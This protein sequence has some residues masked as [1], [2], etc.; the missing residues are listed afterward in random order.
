MRTWNTWAFPRRG[1][2]AAWFFGGLEA[3]AQIAPAGIGDA[4]AFQMGATTGAEG[5]DPT[6]TTD[7]IA[8]G[9]GKYVQI[10]AFTMAPLA[11]DFT[12][13]LVGKFV[14]GASDGEVWS[15]GSTTGGWGQHR[16]F[17]S[18]NNSL[19][20]QSLNQDGGS[21]S[22]GVLVLD[23]SVASDPLI[24][25]IT[26][27]TA[28]NTITLERADTW[29]SVSCT[30]T[31][32]AQKLPHRWSLGIQAQGLGFPGSATLYAAAFA[33]V[34]WTAAEKQQAATWLQQRLAAPPHNC[35]WHEPQFV[36]GFDDGLLSSYVLAFPWLES[37]GVRGYLAL[38]GNTCNLYDHGD[39]YMTWSDVRDLQDRGHEI[40]YHGFN[41]E[42]LNAGQTE[43]QIRGYIESSLAEYTQRGLRVVNGS[44]PGGSVSAASD[45]VYP[46]YFRGARAS[47]ASY[48]GLNAHA[49]DPV[50]LRSEDMDAIV[51]NPAR[52]A[53]L[54]AYV[55]AAKGSRGLFIVL[56]HAVDGTF[57][58]PI[59]ELI[60]YAQQQGLKVRTM[61]EAL[62]QWRFPYAPKGM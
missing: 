60:G 13:V 2:V 32:P 42:Y 4:P 16:L 48:N 52:L 50:H 49:L 5:S 57:E 55:D 62:D 7:S 3:G 10:P 17:Y 41:H 45:A 38:P 29:E 18:G 46:D 47:G 59:K 39:G 19:R 27:S 36:I 11:G 56:G 35:I 21:S 24:L 1:S 31:L 28:T 14:R 40:V 6:I 54:K 23:Q 51:S 34:A 43:A 25:I 12:A 8:V 9:G 22:S 33:N 26:A 30:H 53:G 61:N 15:F 58:A 20:L 37:M 44:Y